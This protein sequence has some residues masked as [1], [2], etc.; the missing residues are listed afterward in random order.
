LSEAD[1]WQQARRLKSPSARAMSTLL[2]IRSDLED[3]QKLMREHQTA[4]DSTVKRGL[5]YAALILYRRAFKSD[6]RGKLDLRKLDELGNGRQYHKYLVG[7]ADK[8]VAHAINPF[9]QIVIGFSKK[10]GSSV[11]LKTKLDRIG[12]L[13]LDVD[14]F[15]N[16]ISFI[17]NNILIEK[18]VEVENI[19]MSE[20]QNISESDSGGFEIMEV[21]VPHSNE[22]GSVS[23]R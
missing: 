12:T 17:I 21:V 18:F 7:M 19:L 1:E 14:Q 13:E 23:Q 6:I 8:H 20:I 10:N 22:V 9:E 3:A 4:G 15:V 11:L 2:G 16:F 5:Y